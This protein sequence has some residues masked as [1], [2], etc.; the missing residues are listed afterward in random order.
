MAS[1][2]QPTRTIAGVTVVDTDLVKAAQQYARAHS[3]DMTYNHVMRSWL[4][5]VTIS[6]K[7]EPFLGPVD[8]EAQAIAAIMHD[9]GWDNTGEL[10]SSDKRFE[11]DGAIAARAWIDKQQKDGLASNL[12][13]S[14]KDLIWDAI[15]L[16]T[17]P[18]IAAFKQP[19][20]QVVGAGI[21]SDFQG[22]TTDPTKTLTWDEYHAVTAEFP[23]LDLA[24]G[25]RRILCGFAETKPQATIESFSE[26]YGVRFIK[27]YKPTY[28]IDMVE[29]SLP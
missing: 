24:A 4:F 3:D 8:P 14:K 5:G 21:A 25:I 1:S 18:S 23:R 7:L 11:V 19:L 13:E 6:K 2:Q 27:G 26:Q 29:N 22:P 17:T 20:V 12:D 28:G 16:H 9:L 15:A 10:I